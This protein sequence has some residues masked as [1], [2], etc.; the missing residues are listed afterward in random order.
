MCVWDSEELVDREPSPIA[1]SGSAGACRDDKEVESDVTVL[2]LRKDS[3]HFV[4]IK[5]DLG[6][7]EEAERGVA[8]QA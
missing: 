2:L 6:C 5:R 1:P 8:T 3:V 7:Y 4:T